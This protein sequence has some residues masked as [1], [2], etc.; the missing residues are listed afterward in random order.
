MTTSD[1]SKGLRGGLADKFGA[2]DWGRL[3][4]LWHDLGKFQLAFQSYIRRESGFDPEAHLE[5]AAPG[6]VNHSSAGAL[7]AVAQFG[8]NGPRGDAIG[9]I[10]AYVIAGHHAGLPDWRQADGG[11]GSLEVRLRH[12]DELLQAATTVPAR[13]SVSGG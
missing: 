1:P 13:P 9:R 8:K 7:H 4:G 11:A 2:E 3:A 10:L 5:D 6:R 12:G